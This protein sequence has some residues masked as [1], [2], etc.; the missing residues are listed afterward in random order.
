MVEELSFEELRKVQLAEKHSP[1]LAPLPE[2]FYDVYFSYLQDRMA[3]LKDNF[4]LDGAKAYE[5]SRKV[6]GDIIKLRSHKI[7]FKAFTDGEANRIV[8]DGLTSQEKIFYHSL[9]RLFNDYELKMSMLSTTQKQSVQVEIAADVP[10][11]V[12]KDGKTLGPFKSGE[13]IELDTETS[14]L[15]LQRGA[16]KLVTA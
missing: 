8:S 3:G 4:S 9:L 13:K 12:G 11:F 16:A 10:E 7:I 14:A 5:N 2:N 15:L 6:L 1:A